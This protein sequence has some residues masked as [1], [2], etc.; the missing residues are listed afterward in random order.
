[1]SKDWS[2][3]RA[4]VVG[5]SIGGLTAA[6][7][8]RRL[9]FEVSV[10]ERTPTSLDGRGGGIVLQPDT[11]RWFAECSSMQPE[12]VSTT[13]RYVQY[14]DSND[15]IVHRDEARWS[16]TSWGTFYLRAAVRFRFR[17]L[18]LGRVR[19]RV[20]R[21]CR[22]CGG[23]IRVGRPPT[24]GTR[25]LRGRHHLTEPPTYLAELRARVLRLRRVARCCSRI[26]SVR[27]DVRIAP[28]RNHI[29]RCTSHPYQR[30]PHP[31]R[32]RWTRSGRAAAELRLVPQR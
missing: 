12:Q 27:R 24:R 4:I 18:P 11:I 29:Q 25:G 19:I 5:G 6:L 20:R 17:S 15:T 21:E 28:R 7:L 22:R 23:S 14:L 32:R 10:Y 9:G 31:L 2:G 13:T 3:N 30:L 16:Y 1:M 26:G 8:L